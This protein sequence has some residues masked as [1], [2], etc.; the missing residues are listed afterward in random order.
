VSRFPRAWRGERWIAPALLLPLAAACINLG[1]SEPVAPRAVPTDRSFSASTRLNQ[2]VTLDE[3]DE[4]TYAFAD[5]YYMV[6]G[7]AVDSIK[8]DNPSP[9]QRRLAHRIKLNGVLAINDIAS[10]PDPYS[11]V[12]DLV[13]AVMLQSMVWIDENR[14][15]EV[16]GERAPILIKALREMRED[17][18]AIGERTLRQDQLETLDLLI[19]DWRR[20]HPQVDQVEYVKFDNF[21]GIRAAA[22]IADLQTG[23]GLMAPAIEM[24]QE[25]REYRRLGERAF[26]YSKRAPNVA[27]IQAEAAV[28]EILA[29]PETEALTVSM[30]QFG[31]TADRMGVLLDSLPSM[32]DARQRQLTGLMR[33][34]NE[35]IGTVNRLTSSVDRTLFTLSGT[36]QVADEV[37]GKYYIPDTT[38]GGK[39]F[40][41]NEYTR[42]LSTAG[43]VVTGM[44]QLAHNGGAVLE[45]PGWR[46]GLAQISAVADR[47]VDRV[48]MHVYLTIGLIF[49]LAVAYRVLTAHLRSRSAEANLPV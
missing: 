27:G 43:D 4:L 17:V 41:I 21:A 39:P 1:S 46:L 49:L 40:D 22:L 30:T 5:R 2:K 25:A 45:S 23:T 31:V 14:A 24:S 19:G 48:F 13:V 15:E 10:S 11:Q 44:N 3:V 36:M 26:W 20:T 29:T 7:S 8:R 47:R 42:A 6:V 12:L 16:F 18:W 33:D 38:S 37:V 32:F 34:A 35:L 28:N 9:E